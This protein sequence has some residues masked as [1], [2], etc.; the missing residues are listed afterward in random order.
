MHDAAVQ[1]AKD[2]VRCRPV[3]HE[4][5]SS[6]RNRLHLLGS[7]EASYNMLDFL[8]PQTDR[9]TSH[10][11]SRACVQTRSRQNTPG[12]WKLHEP[13][14]RAHAITDLLQV[15]C[16]FGY[17][18]T[19]SFLASPTLRNAEPKIFWHCL[20]HPVSRHRLPGYK[21]PKKSTEE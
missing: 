14:T 2:A 1:E 3:Q 4:S 20:R 7:L 21:H 16:I 12:Q 10:H 8:N 9:R 13:Q 6:I 11:E 17:K 19:C 15:S 5:D 18:Y